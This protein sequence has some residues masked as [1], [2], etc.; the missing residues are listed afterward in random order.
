MLS[1]AERHKY[2][3]DRLNKQGYV[4][5]YEIAEELD[6]TT[7]TI[8]KDLKYLEDK[9]LLFRTHGSASPVNPH[10]PDMNIQVKEKQN[11]DAKRRIANA[12][13]ELI[14]VDDSIILGSGTSVYAMAEQIM[15][16][17]NLTVVTSSLNVS[18]LLNKLDDT[19]VIQLGGTL[20]KSSFS[21]VG[22]SAMK[23][24]EEIACSKFFCGVDGIDL[25]YGLTTSN[26]DEARL[27]RCM[28]RS[29]LKLV[30]LADSSKFGRRGFGKICNLDEVD[31]I[32]TDSNIPDAT[33]RV[34]EESGIELII[35]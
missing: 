22:D 21:V 1:I 5:V 34:L 20:R 18:F 9:K 3:L 10:A 29:S 31:V 27:N 24:F 19:C 28:I 11:I 2:I 25:D 35:V 30:V 14:E 26:I 23:A 4:K 15:A 32:I 13:L 16:G 33:A 12:A 6:V 7:V 8:R 17:K